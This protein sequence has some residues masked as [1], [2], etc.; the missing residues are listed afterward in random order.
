M[1]HNI[2]FVFVAATLL[3]TFAQE[4]GKIEGEL[5]SN[6]SFRNVG[7]AFT[8]GRISDIAIH[9]NN[10]NEWYLAMGSG[11]A[12]KTSNHGIT[13]EPIFENYGAYSV[14][15]ITIS[16]SNK[17]TLW[18]GTGENNNQRAIGYG[19]GVYKSLDGGKTWKNMGLKASEHIGNIIVHP[20]NENIVWVAAYG[21]L[22]SEG[23]ERG[24]YITTD[25]GNTWNKTLDISKHTGISEIQIDPTDPNILYAAAHQ[26]RRHVYTYIG[27]GP[28]S[29]VYK[30]TD[31]G[32]TWRTIENGLPSGDMG[33]I[34]L[35]VSPADPNYIY[36]IVEGRYDKGGTY[37]STN[38]GES[39]S[40][41]SSHSTSGNY[42]QEIVCDPLNKYKIFSM[43][44]WLHHSDDGGKTFQPTGESDKHVDNHCIW[45]NPTNTDH[46]IV[47]CDGGLYETYNHAKEWLFYPNLPVTQFYKV[48]VDNDAPFY[49]IYGGTQDN[50]SMGGPSATL[51]T[52]GIVNADWFITNGGDGFESEVDPS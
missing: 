17:N 37:L 25:G 15:C 21:P 7:P 3:T 5:I 34:G 49:N 19:D 52:A 46:F 28:E 27:G 26:R 22:W 6:L 13:F 2:L 11:N 29:G 41:Q 40:K 35:A 44:T 23:G 31:G 36:A 14:A 50:N 45:I 20:T 38:K 47:G 42:Y 33:R 30:S 16:P 18:L 10:T 8:S 39:W 9:P 12:F 1:K 24:V 51:N 32:K 43:D 48:T 4:N